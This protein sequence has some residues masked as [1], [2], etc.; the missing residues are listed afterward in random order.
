MAAGV[1]SSGGSNQVQNPRAKE[2]LEQLLIAQSFVALGSG[3][4][5]RPIAAA[6]AIATEILEDPEE[7]KAEQETLRQHELGRSVPVNAFV[8]LA[9]DRLIVYEDEKRVTVSAR[10]PVEVLAGMRMLRCQSVDQVEFLIE[11]IREV[12]AGE[13]VRRGF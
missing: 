6:I 2:L 4:P 10:F 12:R 7:R 8:H 9:A 13:D 1:A 11:E 3:S 5:A